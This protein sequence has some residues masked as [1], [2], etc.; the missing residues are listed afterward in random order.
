MNKEYLLNLKNYL[1]KYG[2]LDSN[3]GPYSKMYSMTTENIYGFLKNYNLKDKKVLT[4]AA[5][6]DQMLNSYFLGANKV[7]CFD[8]NPLTKLQL[9]LKDEALINLN[10]E[11]FIKFIGI[12]SKKYGDYFKPL[13]SQIFEEIKEKLDLD[14]YLFFDYIINENKNI[15]L[16]D[17]YFP[18]ENELNRLIKMNSY[19]EKDNFDILKKIIITKKINFIE[20]D[21]KDLPD[22]LDKEKYDLILLSNISD[23]IHEIYPTYQLMQ[24][25]ELIE[26]LI[27]HLNYNRTIQVGYIYSTY[28]K[29]EKISNFVLKERRE[30]IFPNKEFNSIMVD[31]YYEENNFDKV[32]IY[33]KLK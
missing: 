10:Y 22:K 15:K 31:S 13:D 3:F 5:S 14:T 27:E 19:L 16:R 4:V 32:I 11:K 17:I 21:I 28:Y 25:R 30:R 33:Q 9:D 24:F 18:F 26:A 29:C 23:Y 7:T 1:K 2:H 12:Y 8:I 20:S 6:G